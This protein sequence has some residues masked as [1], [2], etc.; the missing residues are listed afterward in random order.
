[1]ATRLILAGG[2]LGAG[3]STLLL[4]AAKKLGERGLKVGIVT[5]DQG[6]DLVDTALVKKMDI[7]V[8]EVA[9]GCFCCNF[10]DLMKSIET[11]EKKVNP[12]VILAEP[13]GSCTDLVATILRPMS[14][15][16]PDRFELA[17]L[18]ILVDPNRELENFDDSVAYLYEKQL[19][20]ADLIL[21]TKNDQVSDEKRAEFRNDISKRFP[22]ADYMEIS[23]QKG[24]HIDEWLDY[25]L[26][27]RTNADTG[28]EID[29]ALYGD[30]E[31]TLGW[32]N[33]KGSITS[34]EMF[35]PSSWIVTLMSSIDEILQRSNT[36][37]AHAKIYASPSEDP[38]QA[39]KAS[40]TRT[41][42]PLS[43]D[44]WHRGVKTKSLSFILNLR[45]NMEP[46]KLDPLVRMLLE[47]AGAQLDLEIDLEDFECFAPTPPDPTHRILAD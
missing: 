28:L 43:W 11:L 36:G 32:L 12:D 23:S 34:A 1:M 40:L 14:L 25:V 24:L 39:F 46:D 8:T 7:D 38:S 16:Y 2:F 35:N 5:N 37:I 17:P 26:N 30:A 20:E 31:A 21:S 19:Q 42:Q 9:G 27:N 18:S 13:V 6:K 3:K 44:S 41:G 29:Y 47:S 10:P 15:H 33:T 22:G 4:T 45:V